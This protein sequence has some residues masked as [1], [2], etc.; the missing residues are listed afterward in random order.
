MKTLIIKD[1][2]IVTLLSLAFWSLIKLITFNTH[3]LDYFHVA[4][5]DFQFNDLAFSQ[6]WN[7]IN[8]EKYDDNIIILNIEGAK[9]RADIA[10]AVNAVNSYNPSV[11]GIDLLFEDSKTK[12]EDSC[13]EQALIET[14]STIVLANKIYKTADSFDISK[15]NFD[16]TTNTLGYVNFINTG[17]PQS[18]IRSFSPFERVKGHLDTNFNSLIVK[19]YNTSSYQ[20]LEERYFKK[21]YKDE[22][23][24]FKGTKENYHIITC[25]DLVSDRV[26]RSLIENKIVLIGWINTTSNTII[27]KHFTPMNT[28][29]AGKTLPDMDGVIINAN[30]ISMMLDNSYV[31]KPS[32]F[33][34]WL[35]VFLFG[36]FSI[37]FYIYMDVKHEKWAHFVSK[38]IQTGLSIG[39]IYFGARLLSEKQFALDLGNALAISLLSVDVLYFYE[40]ISKRLNKC[41]G[42]KTIF[43]KH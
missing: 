11:I 13:L 20:I 31:C 9:N 28:K 2:L 5:T 43:S 27:D 22:L 33:V 1:A 40:N 12:Y 19:K 8:K 39:V 37:A 17:E 25:N 32:A 29:I 34:Q 10:D 7:T 21:Q 35:I 18:T 24:N 14:K 6:G 38:I 4:A 26:N 42:Y 3:S 15:G 41:Y 23:I 16:H 36:W 30:I